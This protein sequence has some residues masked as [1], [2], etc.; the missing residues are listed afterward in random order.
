MLPIQRFHQ[1]QPIL[2]G[3]GV[4]DGCIAAMAVVL[5]QDELSARADFVEQP[6]QDGFFLLIHEEVK[7]I[8]QQVPIQ[9]FKR[10]RITQVPLQGKYLR[11]PD[12][13]FDIPLE[14]LQRLPMDIKADHTAIAAEVMCQSSCEN[15]LP[16]AQFCP[17]ASR[18]EIA[19]GQQLEGL[20]ES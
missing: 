7:H 14:S 3:Q 10:K 8:R 17:Q 11:I 15:P 4:G 1:S 5:D 6:A 13:S 9:S 18:F 2:G 20:L 12:G 19:V 16:T